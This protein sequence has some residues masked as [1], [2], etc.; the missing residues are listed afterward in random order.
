MASWT[1]AAR[2]SAPLGWMRP[3]GLLLGFCLGAPAP[4]QIQIH[5]TGRMKAPVVAN[6]PYGP[7]WLRGA[8][9]PDPANRRAFVTEIGGTASPYRSSLETWT[10]TWQA[11]QALYEHQAY[12]DDPASWYTASDEGSTWSNGSGLYG[13]LVVDLQAVRTLARFV[14]FQMFSDGKTTQ[15]TFYSHATTGATP[16]ASTDGGWVLRGG[17]AVGAGT[18]GG[19][20]ITSPTTFTVP[21]FTTRYLKIRALNDGSQ[22]ST[23]YIELK[24]V[25]AFSQ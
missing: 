22:L 14:V 12:L 15:A 25:K 17:G 3:L 7:N 21:A 6:A 10:G 16:P 23:S 11:P 8:P 2:A 5:N 19:T 1:R 24:G 9:T 20:V 4:A 13:E 18:D